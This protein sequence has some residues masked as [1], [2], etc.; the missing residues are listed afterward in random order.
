MP[1]IQHAAL[2]PGASSGIHVVHSWEVANAAARIALAVGGLD[3]GK[4]CRQLDDD[5]YWL[6]RSTSSGAVWL[7]I[8]STSLTYG[9]P[10]D[11]GTTNDAGSG[12][13]VAR[14]NHR[15]AHGN[16]AA[17]TV[18]GTYH[19][20]ASATAFGFMSPTHFT[21]VQSLPATNVTVDTSTTPTVV[22]GT[23]SAA[24]SGSAAAP[25]NHRHQHGNVTGVA[26]SGTYHGVATDTLYGFVRY[27][28][29][30]IAVLS[31]QGS[32]AL[33]VSPDA[34]RVDHRHDISVAAPVAVGAANSAGTA[35]T[36]A[37]SDHVHDASLKANVDFDITLWTS[38][39][40]R[41]ITLA[42]R[43]KL[44]LCQVTTGPLYLIIPRDSTLNLPLGFT[45]QL[46]GDVFGVSLEWAIDIQ[47]EVMNAG[48]YGLGIPMRVADGQKWT[49]DVAPFPTRVGPSQ[50]VTLSKIGADKWTIAGHY[51]P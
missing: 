45:C 35:A 42:D 21:K 33:G 8:G 39:T 31:V 44:I 6:L 29:S 15:H 41:Q 1:D 51:V 12:T 30:G 26:T 32:S 5:S 16:I 14:A 23:A 38:G 24:G 10:V 28:A 34:A 17:T 20:P 22:D 19:A 25:A 27:G 40:T 7:Q 47:S 13:D 49:L 11:I 36:L 18:S 9:A 2:R 4:V 43:N 3:A 48:T 50:R 46:W 37:R